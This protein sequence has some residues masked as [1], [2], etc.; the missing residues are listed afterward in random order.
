[1][2]TFQRIPLEE[3]QKAVMASR[4]LVQTEYRE[5][6]RQ[7]DPDTA[8]QIVLGEGDRAISVRAQLKAA[9]KA[10]G[11]ELEIQ[12]K[13]NALVFWLRGDGDSR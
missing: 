2:A 10:E 5:Y 8:G 11:K 9:A 4:R 7:L 12:R 6:V 13:D 3:A 1:V